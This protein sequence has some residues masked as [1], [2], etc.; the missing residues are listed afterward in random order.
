MSNWTAITIQDL[1]NSQVAPLIDAANS[2]ALGAGQTDRVTGVIAAVVLDIRGQCA[3]VNILDE[4]ASKI[5]NS[6][7]TLAVDMIYCRLKRALQMDLTLDERDILKS[8]ELR[9][10]K[11]GD[12]HGFIDPPDNPIAVNFEQAQPSP[13]FG[14]GKPRRFTDRSQDG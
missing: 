7:K 1:Y 11:I 5:P 8:C 2:V 10:Q 3:R 13:S 14:R 4:D 6:L 9:L 12:G